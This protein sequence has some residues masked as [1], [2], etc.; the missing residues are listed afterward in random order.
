MKRLAIFTLAL[1]IIFITV[2]T[3]QAA[4]S[5][6]DLSGMQLLPKDNIFNTP[7]D[8]LPVD[9]HSDTWIASDFIGVLRFYTAQPYN[10]VDNS[11]VP[12][13][14]TSIGSMWLSDNIPYPIPESAQLH[15]DDYD[16]VLQI[17]NTDTNF[18]Y[19]MYHAVQAQDGTWSASVANYYDMSSNDLRL[20]I[21]RPPEGQMQIKYDEVMSGTIN[22]A[23]Q[24]TISH[25]DDSY[26]WPYFHSNGEPHK[27]GTYPPVGQ[28]FRLKSS[29]DISGFPPQ[30]KTIAQALKTYGLIVTDQH[31]GTTN[32][33]IIG[34]SDPRWDTSWGSPVLST[35]R[36]LSLK[37]FEAV[38]TSSLMIRQDSMQARVTTAAVTPTPTKTP[39]PSPTPTK[40]PTP[41]STPSLTPAPTPTADGQMTIGIYQNGV[42]YLDYN[43]NGIFDT[44]TDKQFN[45][46]SPGWTPV[47]G[48][49]NGDGRMKVGIYKDG[50]W[51]LDMNGNGVWDGPVTD[52]LVT[53]FGLPGW[54]KVTG[55][56]NGDGRIEIGVYKDGTW[57]L[58]RNGNGV[59]DG[60]RTDRLVTAFGLPGW[61]PVTGDW[62][63]DGRIEIGVYK[64]GT[65]YL[66]M[67]RNRV[68]DGP[69]TDRLV[70]AFGLPGWTQVTGDWNGDGRT[71][72]G[73]YKDG[74]WYLDMNGNGVWD[75]TRTDRLVTAFGLPG[76]TQVTGDW[77]GDGRTKV[78]VYKDGTWYLDRN[79]NGV[80][81]GTRTDRLVTAFGSP[82]WTPVIGEWS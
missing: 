29:V 46:G 73:V 37:D 14:L 16:Q 6:S 9:S 41:T 64:D 4:T 5:T 76:W 32:V 61:T 55:D 59:W 66:D 3:V 38:D 72:V 1:A 17:Y 74:T 51:Y 8:K 79:G 42:W 53:A 25:T 39:I 19:N 69:V 43:T 81:D 12:Q 27:D 75:G 57:Y 30:A 23:I 49:W 11:V 63:G 67:N 65:W 78:G 48:D 31:G 71:K 35:L 44:S 70:T 20:N 40:T 82:G 60:T 56:W 26:V 50:T 45:F 77:N 7:V 33:E 28:R 24:A 62:N 18:Y 10:V 58:D 47:I 13:Y 22:H 34:N 52:K 36:T 80:W 15:P 2:P 54:T 21:N 68:W